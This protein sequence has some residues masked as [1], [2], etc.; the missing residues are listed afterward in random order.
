MRQ[1]S[2]LL[3]ALS[4]FTAL[5]FVLW[6]YRY[7][8]VIHTPA[9]SEETFPRP[10]DSNTTPLSSQS[11]QQASQQQQPPTPQSQQQQ[12]QSQTEPHRELRAISPSASVRSDHGHTEAYKKLIEQSAF[13]SS[14]MEETVWRPY[15]ALHHKIRT[16][17]PPEDQRFAIYECSS[18][19]CGG[20]GVRSNAGGGRNKH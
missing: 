19:P 12:D 14:A 18:G 2:Q 8:S 17:V 5:F 13:D 16:Q 20:F 1:S 7:D 10:E 11:N 6:A 9:E 3:L 15:R 4:F